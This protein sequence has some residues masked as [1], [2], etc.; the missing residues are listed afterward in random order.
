MHTNGNG[1][2]KSPSYR[3]RLRAYASGNWMMMPRMFMYAMSWDEA[4]VLAFLIDHADR[5][6]HL[7]KY[8]GWFYCTM[9]KME[10]EL[11][12]GQD[13][14]SR[15]INKLIERG[16]IETR[17]VGTPIMKRWITIK[18]DKLDELVDGVKAARIREKHRRKR[19]RIKRIQDKL[20]DSTS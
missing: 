16:L 11:G 2:H 14:Q 9:N 15:V 17:R 7:E 6:I 4:I 8:K 5:Y 12:I 13:K 18:S 19:D 20:I 3:S 10:W 1:K